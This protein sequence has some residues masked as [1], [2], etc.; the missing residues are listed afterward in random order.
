MTTR[1]TIGPLARTVTAAV[2]ASL[3]GAAGAADAQQTGQSS[4]WGM[5]CCWGPG[6]MTGPSTMGWH[7]GSMPRHHE[8]MMQG[9]P[10]QYAAMTDPLPRSP[11]T[12]AHGAAVYRETCA[13]C[14]GPNGRGDGE[15]GKGLSPP[16]G[17]LAWLAR[18]PMGQWDAYLYWAI[19]EG[20]EAFGT[21]MPAHKDALSADD[22]WA[23][24]TYIEAGIP[25]AS[26]GP[27]R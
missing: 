24:V 2:A 10:A 27:A 14:H 25:A 3:C 26:S 19:A 17:D 12:L 16:P 4:G 23:V 8:A 6:P 18:M 5:G 11:E 7:M 21:G 13:S 15:A 20:G 9:I 1:R 22:I